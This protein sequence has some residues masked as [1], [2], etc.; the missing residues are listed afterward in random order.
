MRIYAHILDQRY[1]RYI[2]GY[3]IIAEQVYCNNTNIARISCI[4]CLR[5]VALCLVALAGDISRGW[6]E[7]AKTQKHPDLTP[8][9][10]QIRGFLFG[11]RTLS[12]P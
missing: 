1:N 7:S 3:S 5:L 8:N 11:P 2:D 4:H 9:G 12:A 6:P 10:G